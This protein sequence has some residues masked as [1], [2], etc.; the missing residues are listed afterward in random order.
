L[1]GPG[2]FLA[3]AGFGLVA[4]LTLLFG[5][6]GCVLCAVVWVIRVCW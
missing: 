2:V 6:A 5:A 3:G 4:W 1:C